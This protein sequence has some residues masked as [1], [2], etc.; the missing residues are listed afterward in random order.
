MA[1]STV[2]PMQAIRRAFISHGFQGAGC[3]HSGP[4]SVF[5]CSKWFGGL[6]DRQ[7]GHG[8]FCGASSAGWLE[9]KLKNSVENSVDWQFI[10]THFPPWW[11]EA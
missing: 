7:Q 4:Y 8:E 6:W 3:G 1:P 11:G 9:S 5:D 2:V 10:V